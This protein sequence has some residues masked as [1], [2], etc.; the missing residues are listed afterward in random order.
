MKK[1]L[2]AVAITLLALPFVACRVEK[3]GEDT[4][5]VEAPTP[6]AEAAAERAAEETREAG[7]AI[8][9]GAQEAGAAAVEGTRKAGQKVGE[10]LEEAGKEMQEHSKPGDQP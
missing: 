7:Q 3:T 5:Q 8:K 2:I 6:E 4:Y 9:E 10:A 1:T